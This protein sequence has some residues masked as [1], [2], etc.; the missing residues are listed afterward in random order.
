M[1]KSTMIAL[2]C[3]G[4]LGLIMPKR[5]SADEWNQKTVFTFSGPVEI[6]GQV[7]PAGTYVFKLLDSQS[8]RDIVQ[9]FNKNQDHLYGTFLAIPDYRLRPSG[10]TIV[11]FEERAAGAPEAVRAWFYPGENFGHEFV[12]PKAKAVEL[13]KA[14][15]QPVASMPNEMAANTNQPSNSTQQ[16][17][18]NALKQTPLKAQKPTGEEYEITEVFTPPPAKQTA[19]AQQPTELPKTASN[20]PLIALIGLLSLGTAGVLRFAG[21]KSN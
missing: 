19:A 13:A 1:T 10:K 3:V 14:N 5:A 18:T 16:P 8:D 9:V 15:N 2:L 21:A 17:D 4:S 7:L 6:P 20:L 12:Y 11:T